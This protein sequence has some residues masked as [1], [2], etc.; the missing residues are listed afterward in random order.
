M[1]EKTPNGSVPG[2]R[3]KLRVN[4][5]QPTCVEISHSSISIST[6]SSRSPLDL[7][8]FFSVGEFFMQRE[9]LEKNFQLESDALAFSLG[10]KRDVRRGAGEGNGNFSQF[11]FSQAHKLQ[12]R[13][14]GQASLHS[15][16]K[17]IS[18][19]FRPCFSR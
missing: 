12:S 6:E 15:K 8:E 7:L 10:R 3:G 18:S 11:I 4:V 17:S 19:S 2:W 14:D 5:T 13:A 16:K 1:S 9:I